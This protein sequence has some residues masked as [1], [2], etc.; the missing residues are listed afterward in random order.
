MTTASASEP[1]VSPASL[2]PWKVIQTYDSTEW[3]A[4]IHEWAEGFDPPYAQVVHLG[5]P[6][7]AGRDVVGYVNDPGDR[8]GP[9]DSYQCKHYNRP[10]RPTDVYVELGKLCYHSF[11]GTF[12]LPRIYRFVAPRGIGPKLHDL[13]RRP[14]LLRVELVKNWDDYYRTK[15]VESEHIALTADLR[16]YV[17]AFDFSI[18]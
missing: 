8:Q 5:G 14:E 16:A 3:E 10:L 2:T 9:W 6:G 11:S 1:R 15:I 18:V 7:D 12:S 13:L 4:F 17:D